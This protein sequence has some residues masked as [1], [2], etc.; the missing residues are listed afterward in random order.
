MSRLMSE[1]WGS[2]DTEEQMLTKLEGEIKVFFAQH[3]H[4]RQNAEDSQKAI[5]ILETRVKN[6]EE[7]IAKH[8]SIDTLSAKIEV[9]EAENESLK[10][11]LKE[12]SEEEAKKK[13][14]LLEKHAQDMA[15][16]ADKLKKS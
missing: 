16:L 3:K 13:K 11:F 7:E 10:N 12:S 14:E 1:V 8:P 4:V 2:P 6:Y 15:E 9:L 5:S